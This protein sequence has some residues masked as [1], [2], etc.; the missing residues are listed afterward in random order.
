MNESIGDESRAR[1]GLSLDAARLIEGAAITVELA[2][3]PAGSGVGIVKENL[4]F[5]ESAERVAQAGQTDAV[6]ILPWLYAGS[7]LSAQSPSAL[8][9]LGVGF[10]VSCGQSSRFEGRGGHFLLSI[11][12]VLGCIEA[13]FYVQIFIFQH[14]SRSTRSTYLCTAPYS[15]F[16]DFF[17][18]SLKNDEFSR[19]LQI[20]GEICSNLHFFAEIFTDFYRN[21]GKC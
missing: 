6:R 7:A 4:A 21:C 12:L 20:F 19:F 15:K 8:A 17:E 5:A 2:K 9:A 18:F 10:V 14:F 3:P 16:A 11:Y 13:E 1:R